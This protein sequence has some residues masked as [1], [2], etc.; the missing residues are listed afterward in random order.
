[1]VK[2]GQKFRNYPYE[3][4]KKPYDYILRKVGHTAESWNIW[5]FQI[6]TG[7]KYG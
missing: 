5:G 1:M 6:D 3:L 4:K 2:K 7:L